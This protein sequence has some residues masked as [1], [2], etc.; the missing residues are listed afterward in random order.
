MQK[1][2]FLDFPTEV[3]LERVKDEKFQAMCKDLW[4]NIYN[5]MGK[6]GQKEKCK[7]LIQNLNKRIL[8]D[9]VLKNALENKP[10]ACCSGCEKKPE[11][12]PF[13]AMDAALA[14][15]TNSSPN[16]HIYLNGYEEKKIFPPKPAT[17]EAPKFGVNPHLKMSSYNYPFYTT[18]YSEMKEKKCPKKFT[19]FLGMKIEPCM[20]TKDEATL[21]SIKETQEKL[22]MTQRIETTTELVDDLINKFGRLQTEMKDKA[23]IL[24][25]KSDLLSDRE[26]IDKEFILRR[27]IENTS[28]CFSSC[29]S[30]SR[31]SRR[32][33]SP[34]TSPYRSK[35][36]EVKYISPSRSISPVLHCTK[37][38]SSCSRE[39]LPL[40]SCLK[41]TKSPAVASIS[42]RINERRQSA[43]ASSAETLSSKDLFYVAPKVNC[44]NLKPVVDS[45]IY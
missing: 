32:C 41:R 1:Y 8:C 2:S 39:H 14:G 15:K 17:C 21:N 26:K 37:K 27:S 16:I 10:N 24:K 13:T 28:S 9:T 4:P 18:K 7:D 20:N 35:S 12:L 11:P 34:C 6:Q 40:K 31:E 38:L 3:Q 22:K 25:T 19:D 33:K 45:K 43:N 42:Y 23:A 36:R 44:W 30:V 29:R 5:Q